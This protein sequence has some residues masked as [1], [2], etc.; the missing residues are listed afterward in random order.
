MS[1]AGM[2]IEFD[3][4]SLDA[5]ELPANIQAAPSLVRSRHRYFRVI[6][7]SPSLQVTVRPVAGCSM[8]LG[9]NDIA[10]TMH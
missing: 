2:A 3:S 6:K 5:T 4:G 10:I 7:S 1:S 9:S 8:L